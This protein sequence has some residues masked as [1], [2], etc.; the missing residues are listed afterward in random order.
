MPDYSA[1]P[2]TETPAPRRVPV[3]L[4][5][6]AIVIGL[7][8][9]ALAVPG[10]Y[11][12]ILK[13]SPYYAITGL[14]LIATAAMLWLRQRGA[15]ILYAVILVGTM[16]WAYF[17]SGLDFWNLAPRGD[18]LVP[19]GIWLALP[20]VWSRLSPAR[21]ADVVLLTLA[22][23]AAIVFC[24]VALWQTI[25][26]ISGV[27]APAAANPNPPAPEAAAAADWTAY[28]ATSHG[29][30]YSSL[31]QITPANVAHLKLA[32]EFHTGD[33]RNANEDPGEYTNEATPIKIGDTLYTCSPH[34]IVFA[35]DATTGK[36]RWRFDPK[37][38]HNRGFQHMTCR[39]VSYHQTAPNATAADGILAPAECPARIFLPTD[40]GR[41]FALDAATG[42]PCDGFG[43]HGFVNLKEGS[44]VQT[45]GF[46]EG[47]SPP[48]V[49]DKLV[50]T[51]GAVIDNWSVHVPSGV[52][53][54]YD[55]YSGKLV[56]V[57]DAGNPDPNEMP[58][59]THHFTPGS[60]NA[61]APL[62]ADE[63]LGLVYVPLGTSAAD[64]WGGGRNEAFERYDSALVALDINTGKLRWSFQN[65][66]HDLWDMDM[67]SQPSLADVTTEKG[68]VPAIYIP[69][70]TGDIFVLDRRDG[71]QIVPAPEKPVPQGAASGDRLSP[72]QP[73]SQL[74][75][76]PQ[77]NVL[78]SEMWG[79]TM[80]DQMVCRILFKRLRYDGIFTPPTVQGTLVFPGDF[81]MFEWGGI[82][83]DANRRVAIANPMAMPFISRLIPRGPDNPDKP[84][85][86]LPAG[87]EVGVQ[88]MF[89]TPFGVKLSPFLSPIG[90]PCLQ[91]PWGNLAAIDL[92]TNRVLWKRRVGTIR[93]MA[94]IPLPFELGV[95]MLGGP[96]VTKGGVAFLTGTMDDYIR[97]FDVTSGKLLW[98]DRLP[99]GGQST[100][101]T[102][103]AGGRQYVVTVAGGH[104]SFG[105]KL[106]DSV[107][108]Y[109]L[110]AGPL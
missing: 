5:I 68:T 33:L 75:F 76:R 72:T 74:S 44:E 55:V 102:Y 32:W 70:K 7:I 73:F 6:T 94:P 90:I 96:M 28:G 50:I 40:D 17:E 1:V 86:K 20:F 37:I 29:T 58:S 22:D 43:D 41:L 99:A 78:E 12:I 100:P 48:V 21:A 101:M 106:G 2:P 89:G 88:P 53:R 82:A 27:P 81:G 77:H 92:K 103:E 104:G 36:E 91:P 8:G 61:W 71:S 4:V 59:P 3:I 13:G 45:A 87:Q 57:F 35:L 18:I 84:N 80:I 66:H 56:W 38:E 51:G 25:G 10:L 64:Q 26:A 93:D 31:T 108:A 69:A 98:Q 24:G 49:T 46:Y 42:K 39:G 63:K 47:T 65:V 110:D 85:D 95:P 54:A 19:I 67:P 15:L 109:V 79:A 30:R 14:A 83:V 62:A 107:R 16:I 23:I 105:T 97:A 52:I 11:L 9:F 34:Q 60:P